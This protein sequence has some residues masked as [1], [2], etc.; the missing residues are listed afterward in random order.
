M[1][2]ETVKSMRKQVR[3]YTKNFVMV[4]FA[5]ELKPPNNGD[6]WFCSMQ[7][8]DGKTFGEMA[9]PT[10]DHILSHIDEQYYVASLLVNAIKKFPVSPIA[11]HC[12]ACLWSNES[13]PDLDSIMDLMKKQIQWALNRY[14]YEQLNCTLK[15]AV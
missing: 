11:N 3:N 10:G 14:C 4:L 12:I 2:T 13:L 15:R 7:T 6:C 8:E 5:G 1:I 9:D